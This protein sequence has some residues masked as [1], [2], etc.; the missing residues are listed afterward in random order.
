MH[1]LDKCD[2]GC[3]FG[4]TCSECNLFRPTYRT[5]RDGETEEIMD[6]QIN[7]LARYMSDSLQALERV[8]AAVESRG[9]D[10]VDRQ[11]QFLSMVKMSARKNLER[12]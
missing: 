6:C 4:H 5:R 9:N 11:D 12:R 2:K 3:P 8:Q 7:H 10:M 1:K